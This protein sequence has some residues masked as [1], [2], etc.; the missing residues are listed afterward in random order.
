[1]GTR[2]VPPA[3]LAGHW[4]TA[5]G[6]TDT[7][8]QRS[9]RAKWNPPFVTSYCDGE[10]LSGSRCSSGWGLVVVG[11]G[12]GVCVICAG[13]HVG[14]GRWAVERY[15]SYI[16]HAMQYTLVGSPYPLGLGRLSS[17]VFKEGVTRGEETCRLPCFKLP[18]STQAEP[19][20]SAAFGNVV[21][22]RLAH[23]S[24]GEAGLY[25]DIFPD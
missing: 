11:Q 19:V 12:E 7:S 8:R 20:H 9:D 2:A 6:M 10:V 23:L 17:L 13:E 5:P 24:R 25:K 14:G 22:A 4:T 18:L 21:R 1:M 3:P 16:L 15:L